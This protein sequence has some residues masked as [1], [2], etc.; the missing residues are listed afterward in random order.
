MAVLMTRP[1]VASPARSMAIVRRLRF[2]LTVMWAIAVVLPGLYVYA[3]FITTES[4]RAIL[5]SVIGAAAASAG[6][7]MAL[8]RVNDF[9]GA[10]SYSNILPSI[11]GAYGL[12]LVLFFG[13]RL[14]YSRSVFGASF[15]LAILMAFVIVY[16]TE[17]MVQSR[18]AIVP[19]GDVDALLDI[20][21]AEW[22][23]MKEPAVPAD[24]NV[25]LVADFRFDHNDDWERTLARAA[26]AG[27]TVYHSKLLNESLTGRVTIEHLSENNFGSL[28]PNLA[29]SKFKRGV[30]L[31]GCLIIAPFLL[32]VGIVIAVLIKLDSRGSVFFRQERVGYRGEVFHMFKF[33]TM[34]PREAFTDEAAARQ[35]AMTRSDDNRV[36][37]I[38]RFLR[39]TRLD[40][41]PQMVNILRGE[42]SWIGPRPEAVPLSK[43]Y[44][45]EIP[46]YSYRHIIRPGISGWAQVHQGHVTD[47]EAIHKKLSYDFYYVK[48]FSA[49]LDIVIALRTV[50]T[51]IGGFGAK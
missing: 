11:T 1:A 28:L 33:R 22:V 35:D 21:K 26:V 17:R 14:A 16:L 13:L 20:Q 3:G 48:Y 23:K 39:R 5:N 15:V 29:Y 10:R 44:E 45:N 9:P 43:W 34:R 50:S 24:P 47:L 46:F 19:G 51:M 42:M 37:R 6:A 7:L 30:D 32:I 36:T 38:G 4:T 49:W 41:L 18:F 40:E 12:T 31:L 25:M 2:Q 27:R 8:R